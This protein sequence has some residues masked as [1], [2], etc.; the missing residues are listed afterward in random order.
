MD[1]WGRP[2]GLSDMSVSS[3]SGVNV[4]AYR[5]NSIFFIFIYHLSFVFYLP[6]V[7]CP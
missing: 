2:K 5:K 4:G 3:Y 7:A 1:F 6:L